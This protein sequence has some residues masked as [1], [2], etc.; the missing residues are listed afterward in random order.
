[1]VL[2]VGVEDWLKSSL[3]ISKAA[4][5]PQPEVALGVGGSK[6]RGRKRLR[7][8]LLA[9]LSF[10]R[11]GCLHWRRVPFLNTSPA[12]RS[13]KTISPHHPLFSDT[14]AQESANSTSRAQSSPPPAFV[15]CVSQEWFLHLQVVKIKRKKKT[16]RGKIVFCYTRKS[17]E[18]HISVSINKVRRRHI[19]S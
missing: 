6:E 7:S 18:I 12:K 14:I 11:A 5:F 1:M 9:L 10:T 4:W 19:L 13:V 3:W 17:D 15:W 2:G 8:S 16:N